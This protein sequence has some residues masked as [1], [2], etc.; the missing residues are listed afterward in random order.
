[1]FWDCHI[2]ANKTGRGGMCEPPCG[3]HVEVRGQHVRVQEMTQR[4][5]VVLATKAEDL[6]WI[7][8]GHMAEKRN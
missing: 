3:V 8:G 7:P 2:E 4:V 6:S 1:M 5:T